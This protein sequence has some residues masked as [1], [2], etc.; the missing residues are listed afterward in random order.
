MWLFLVA[1]VDEKV[2]VIPALLL[3]AHTVFL[4]SPVALR[5]LFCMS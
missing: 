1:G 2:F 3:L 4:S 5:S